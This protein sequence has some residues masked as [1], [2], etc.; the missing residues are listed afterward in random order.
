LVFF[1]YVLPHSTTGLKTPHPPALSDDRGSSYAN[2]L[3]FKAA[4]PWHYI[5]PRLIIE[6]IGAL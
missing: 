1:N 2:R 3:C 5:F 4:I 6:H